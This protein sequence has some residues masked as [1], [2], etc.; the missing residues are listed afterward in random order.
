MNENRYFS[1]AF[2]QVDGEQTAD[3][4]IFGDIVSS[5]S[6]GLDEALG[7]DT[8][9]V[10]AYSLSKEINALSGDIATI[11]V[12]INSFGGLTNE[13]V[14]IFSALRQ[15]PAHII[16]IVDGFACSAA[17]VVFMAGDERIMNTASVFM[18][19]NAWSSATGNAHDMREQ[20]DILD[21]ISASAAQ[22]YMRCFTGTREELDELLDGPDHDGTWLDA[23]QC[24]GYGF[25]TSIVSDESA[26]QRP[27]QSVKRTISKMLFGKNFVSEKEIHTIEDE[28]KNEFESGMKTPVEDK[29]DEPQTFAA[30]LFKICGGQNG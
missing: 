16:T 28:N 10:S 29:L 22:A 17:S 27:A 15:H 18:L 7:F 23:T 26:A 6:T 12:H 8:G 19:H 9:D 24:V 14:A 1:I 5:F 3:I 20:A 13:G 2:S 4:Y 30:K 25:A 11:R 21:I